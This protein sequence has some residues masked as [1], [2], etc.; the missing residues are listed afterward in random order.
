MFH[1][2]ET[3]VSCRR[4]KSFMLQKQL[5]QV[6]GYENPMS[7]DLFIVKGDLF[8]KCVKSCYIFAKIICFLSK[9]QE[10]RA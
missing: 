3:R 1:I 9:M 10:K 6:S 4:N 5:C 8:R 2:I 7:V